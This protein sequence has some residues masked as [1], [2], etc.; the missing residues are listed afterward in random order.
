[1]VPCPRWSGEKWCLDLRAF[2]FGRYVLDAPAPPVGDI[3][4]VHAA[5]QLLGRLR[6]DGSIDEPAQPRLPGV[7][8]L[9]LETAIAEYLGYRSSRRRWKTLGGERWCREVCGRLTRELGRRPLADFEPPAGSRLLEQYRDLVRKGG[10]GRQI[11]AKRMRD[12]FIVLAQ[13]FHFAAATDRAWM[14]ACPEIPDPTVH[15]GEVVR[16]SLDKWV[17]EQTFRVARAE[18]Y[19][20]GRGVVLTWLRTINPAATSADVDDLVERRRLFL[21]FAFYTGMRRHDLFEMDDR[22]VS[23]DLGRYARWSR[24]TDARPTTEKCPQPLLIDL[25]V[26]RR[27]LGRHWRRGE[28]ICG[29]PWLGVAETV[30][31]ACV[32]AHV[33]RFNLM[34]CR[35]SFVWHQAAAGVP[36][37]KMIRLMGHVDSTMIRTVYLQ[38]LPASET[39]GYSGRW[40]AS[41]SAQPGTGNARILSIVKDTK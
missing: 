36:E 16:V 29:G 15:T 35:R 19:G 14:S 12:L 39:D 10:L 41:I 9:T 11:A 5:W 2:G 23:P 3:P 7:D 8:G 24:K 6:A 28:A 17:D 33:E 4:A 22:S 1:M 25:D 40:P 13:V 30:A 31:A 34:D 38:H 18:I 27:R 32:R 21:S 20:A 37:D 26:E